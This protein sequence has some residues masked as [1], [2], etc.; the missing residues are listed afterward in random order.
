ME[1]SVL[2]NQSKSLGHNFNRSHLE[3]CIRP[4]RTDTPKS[5]T[6]T[7][8]TV[9]EPA[10]AAVTAE[11]YE[12]NKLYQLDINVINPDPDQPRKGFDPDE[13]E[14]LTY[15]VTTHGIFNALSCRQD[16]AGLVFII[17]GERR[18]RA[19]K[20]AG[21][22]K[23]PVVF[24]SGRTAEIAIIDNM[25]RSDFS[26]I[27][28][29]EAL[30]KLIN[31]FGYKQV[32]LGRIV[33]RAPATIS[34]IIALNSLP[35][36]VKDEIRGDKSYSRAELLPIVVGKDKKSSGDMVEMFE[37]LKSRKKR[38]GKVKDGSEAILKLIKS[39]NTKI[40]KFDLAPLSASKH[41]AIRKS[42][43]DLVQVINN[44]FIAD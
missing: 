42:L 11:K 4:T 6:V 9:T 1:N 34:E 31:N 33:N 22:A 40:T 8:S 37:A 27:E 7:V 30:E 24:K 21:Q 41:G 23:V 25:Q 44:K 26:P 15:S 29:A 17:A 3:V 43:T 16:E 35:L 36:S 14:N 5:E 28:E 19:A 38:A 32:E 2:K 13:M 39:L 10:L 12:L 20:A 18:F